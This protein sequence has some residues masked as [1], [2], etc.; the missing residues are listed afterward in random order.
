MRELNYW[1]KICG[2]SKFGN[3]NEVIR[4]YK[5]SEELKKIVGSICSK[6]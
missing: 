4:L 2:A 3:E 1:L 5:E 6:L